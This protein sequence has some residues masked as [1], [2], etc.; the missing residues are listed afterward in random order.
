[1]SDA[2][3]LKTLLEQLQEIK[4]KTEVAMEWRRRILIRIS[5]AVS[6]LKQDPSNKESREGIVTAL[7]RE[8]Q[9]LEMVRKGTKE[10]IKILNRT[11]N[12]L[13]KA[14]MNELEKAQ[15]LQ[16]LQF[17][18][19]AMKFAKSKIKTLEKRIEKGEMLERVDYAGKYLDG[20]LQTLDEESSIDEELALILEGK[21]EKVRS[22]LN[23]LKY[24]LRKD[25]LAKGAGTAVIDTGVALGGSMYY[26]GSAVPPEDAIPLIVATIIGAAAAIMLNFSASTF[27]AEERR[28]K[29]AKEIPF[30]RRF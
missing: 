19:D 26:T 5:Q 13:K 4:R 15:M 24:M 29:G 6:A 17:L 7:E 3:D 1:M 18:I 22:K 10:G 8:E 27:M 28:R 16:L 2:S 23:I 20:F 25:I 21:S 14:K 11:R 30:W 9:F 12:V